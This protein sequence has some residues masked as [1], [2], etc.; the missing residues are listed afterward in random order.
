[1]ALTIGQ[2]NLEHAGLRSGSEHRRL[3]RERGHRTQRPEPRIADHAHGRADRE[4]PRRGAS[5]GV[6]IARG[7]LCQRDHD[8]GPHDARADLGRAIHARGVASVR[9]QQR[10]RACS[11]GDVTEAFSHHQGDPDLLTARDRDAQI[12]PEQGLQIGIIDAAG[13][14]RRHTE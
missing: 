5:T 3:L 12:M 8:L 6:G 10:V 4:L 9:D 1:H 14:D 7:F 11:H 2:R 13:H